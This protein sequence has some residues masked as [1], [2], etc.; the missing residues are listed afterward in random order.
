[1][2]PVSSIADDRI[3]SPGLRRF[4]NTAR[5]IARRAIRIADGEKTGAP[6]VRA[7]IEQ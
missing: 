2:R 6:A 1:L 4:L 5:N 7:R 3:R